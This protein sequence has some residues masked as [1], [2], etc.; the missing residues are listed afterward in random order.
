MKLLNS[1]AIQAV[2]TAHIFIS[3]QII[4]LALSFWPMKEMWLEPV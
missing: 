2:L 3:W 1:A 4:L